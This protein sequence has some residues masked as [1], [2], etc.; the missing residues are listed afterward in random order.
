M[1]HSQLKNHIVDIRNS[2]RLK[3][4]VENYMQAW[5]ETP[6]DRYG[7]VLSK[8]ERKPNRFTGQ[9]IPYAHVFYADHL[10]WHVRIGLPRGLKQYSGSRYGV[11]RTTQLPN[12]FEY[13]GFADMKEAARA[14]AQIRKWAVESLNTGDYS[15]FINWLDAGDGSH[16]YYD[17]KGN[18]SNTL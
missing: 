3:R 16:R 18:W 7:R 5:S 6:V 13:V 2:A 15:N 14:V 4:N 9:S 8:F 12:G 10:G 11:S 17:A 1:I